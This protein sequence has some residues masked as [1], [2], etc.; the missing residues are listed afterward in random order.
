MSEQASGQSAET[1]EQSPDRWTAPRKIARQVVQVL[2]YSVK[3]LATDNGPHWAAALSYYALL[4]IF[5]MLLAIVSIASYFVDP[6]W[7]VGQATG[8]LGEFLPEGRELVEETVRALMED[9]G[10]ASILSILA[11]LWTGSRV[12]RALT[13]ALNIA[14]DTEE[15]YGFG[16]RILMELA[17]MLTLGVLFVLAL[18]SG[19]LLRLL[20]RALGALPGERGFAFG[21]I[22]AAV[23]AVL[24]LAALFLIYRFVPRTRTEWKSALTGALAATGLFMLARPL[25]GYYVQ[26]FAGYSLV[27][28]SL[29]I[30]I[31]LLV[32]AWL[33]AMIVILGGEIASHVQM[34]VIEGKSPEE[35]KRR[36]EARS[37]ERRPG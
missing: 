21:L 22:T 13:L 16:K 29:S 14:Y 8:L 31:V 19:P 15:T 12:F 10:P 23:P 20:G 18:A 17:M 33:G 32:W 11:L 6:Q 34:I 36:H 2:Y 4:S 3:D 27:Y 9:R 24:L 5:P 28:G 30:V 37:P 35:V 1:P 7:A 26:E 25:F